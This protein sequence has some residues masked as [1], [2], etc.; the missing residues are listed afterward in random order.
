MHLSPM[1]SGSTLQQTNTGKIAIHTHFLWQKEV[2]QAQG[3]FL[4]CQVELKDDKHKL[5]FLTFG[6]DDENTSLENRLNY[7]YF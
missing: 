3:S 2:F 7:I 4:C 1:A 5:L 6:D